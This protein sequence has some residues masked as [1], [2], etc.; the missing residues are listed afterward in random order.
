MRTG[1]AGLA[2]SGVFI[3][4]FAVF[5]LN[6]SHRADF[7][8][9]TAGG[10]IVIDFYNAAEHI[11]TSGAFSYHSIQLSVIRRGLFDT[12]LVLRNVFLDSLNLLGDFLSIAICS[13]I[14]K[15]GSQLSTI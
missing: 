9:N 4:G 10:A 6:V 14:S 8:T 2:G 1:K 5:N 11:G 7:G 12:I 13:F 15:L 3:F